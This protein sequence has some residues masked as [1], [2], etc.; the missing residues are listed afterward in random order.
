MSAVI[1][2]SISLNHDVAARLEK[3]A[4]QTHVAFSR[5]VNEAL[6]EYLRK[7]EEDA[8]SVAYQNYYAEP[9]NVKKDQQASRAFLKLAK[10][11]WA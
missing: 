10:K 5:M 1:K 9:E 2:K 3:Q 7:M 11:T 8:L 4:A 6:S